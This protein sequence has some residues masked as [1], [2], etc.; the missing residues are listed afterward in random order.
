MAGRN[1]CNP[2]PAFTWTIVYNSWQMDLRLKA[3]LALLLFFPCIKVN[4]AAMLNASTG[5]CIM[6]LSLQ[7]ASYQQTGLFAVN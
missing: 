6:N 1:N 5:H 2:I 3:F 4:A 7:D